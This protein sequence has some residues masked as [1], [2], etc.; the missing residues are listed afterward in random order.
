MGAAFGRKNARRRLSDTLYD[1]LLDTSAT[2]LAARAKPDYL[3]EILALTLT[4]TPR[5]RDGTGVVVVGRAHHSLL[6]HS[7]IGFF[8]DF[9]SRCKKSKTKKNDKKETL[10]VE[11]L[12]CLGVLQ[13]TGFWSFSPPF[14]CECMLLLK[15]NVPSALGTSSSDEGSVGLTLTG[16]RYSYL[17]PGFGDCESRN[18][19]TG[20]F[21]GPSAVTH[22]VM[23]STCRKLLFDPL[24][25]PST[26][27]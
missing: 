19:C 11:N 7:Q 24:F 1:R 16:R 2:G 27:R 12:H 13:M 5:T 15:F 22:S 21:V 26:R 6:W 3:P 18:T 9:I 8:R 14:F 17:M 25:S 20:S 4:N 10:F 23:P